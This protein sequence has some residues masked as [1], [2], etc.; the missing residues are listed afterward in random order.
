MIQAVVWNDGEKWLTA[1]DTS[2]MH[3]PGSG[4]GTL[5]DFD[6]LDDFSSSQRFGT[7]SAE[8]SCNYGVHVYEDG[9]VL[10]IIVECGAIFAIQGLPV[11]ARSLAACS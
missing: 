8:D 7:F 4:L 5:A 9:K 6:P 11:R 2:D 1:L 3:P 10:S